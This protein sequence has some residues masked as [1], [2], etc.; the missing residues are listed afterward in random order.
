MEW[1]LI[2][3]DMGCQAVDMKTGTRG[4]RAASITLEFAIVWR[5]L[6]MVN[7]IRICRN[8]ENSKIHNCPTC[9][10]LLTDVQF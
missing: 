7:I 2:I 4:N 8:I 6:V 3:E 1:I 10:K 5:S 9:W